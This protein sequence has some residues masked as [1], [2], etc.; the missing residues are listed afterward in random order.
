MKEVK[1]IAATVED[2]P[3]ILKFIRELAIY[4]KLEHEVVATEAMLKNNL[5]GEERFAEVLFIEVNN[6]KVG[7]ALFFKNFSTFLGVPGIYLEDL[8]VLP[9]YRGT[10]LGKKLLA[11]IAKIAIDR[12]YGRFEWSVLDWNTPAINF[13][14]SIGALPMNEWTVQRLTGDAL[15]KLADL[16][17]A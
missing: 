1:I 4:E 12:G 3:D 10:G 8:F 16:C 7:F 13:Y 6:K 9:E 17:I 11:Y 2:T 15:K 5:F 14:N